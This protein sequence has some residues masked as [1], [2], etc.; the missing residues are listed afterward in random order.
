MTGGKGASGLNEDVEGA[1][2]FPLN[3]NSGKNRSGDERSVMLSTVSPN[4]TS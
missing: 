1:L 4:A 3:T 2:L